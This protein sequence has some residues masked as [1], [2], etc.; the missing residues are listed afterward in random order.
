MSRKLH[1][2]LINQEH[3][4]DSTI[5]KTF[6]K[7]T[8]LVQVNWPISSCVHLK[9]HAYLNKQVC[10]SMCDLLVDTRY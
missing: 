10:L 8:D 9:G 4:E 3:L 6:Y 7:I 1:S 5:W 2:T